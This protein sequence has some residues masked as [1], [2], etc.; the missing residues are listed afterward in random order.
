MRAMIF[1]LLAMV[2][3]VLAIACG[4]S[5]SR[6]VAAEVGHVDHAEQ[7]CLQDNAQCDPNGVAC[8]SGTCEVRGGTDIVGGTCA[9][10]PPAAPPPSGGGRG[11]G[12]SCDPLAAT[13]ATESCA[14]G[15]VCEPLGDTRSFACRSLNGG[16]SSSG[17]PIVGS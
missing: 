1:G 14:Q 11:D 15:F 16:G 12:Q 10:S 13:G 3:P 4:G 5:E 2:G 9:S 7:A 8:C 17:Q 6:G